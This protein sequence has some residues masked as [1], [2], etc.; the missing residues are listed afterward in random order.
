MKTLTRHLILHI[1]GL[2]AIVALALVAVFTFI[3]FIAEIDE[4]GQ[5][6]FGV[7]QLVGY[8]VL[9]LP[10]GLYTL[11]PII[12]MLGTLLGLGTL[13][14]QNELTAMRAAGVSLRRIGLATLLA[15]VGLGLLSLALG[16][17]IAPVGSRTAE[18]FKTLSRTGVAAGIG[19]QAV[20]LRDGNFVFHIQRLLAEDHIAEVEVFELAPDLSLRAAL[21]VAEARYRDDHWVFS[22]VKRSEFLGSSVAAT[23]APTMDWSGSLSPEVLRLF[24]LEANSLTAPGL[25]RLINYMSDN[26][27][28]ASKYRLSLWRKLVAPLTVIAMMIFAIPFVLGPLRNSGTGQRLLI[29]V[30]IGLG[31]YVLN[32]VTASFGQLYGWPPMLAA[33]LPTAV[34]AGLGVYRLSVAR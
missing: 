1:Y 5:G 3:S 8:T 6:G 2:T 7:L 29:G 28:D 34:F 14:S 32:E 30:L 11:M 33:G 15:G 18:S 9:M 31:F 10:T 16:D 27:L 24:V 19:G 20:W 12:A 4:T 26:G 25:W 23:T 13:A 17:W 21:R 22:G